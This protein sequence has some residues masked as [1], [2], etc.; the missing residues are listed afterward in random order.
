MLSLHNLFLHNLSLGLG[1]NDSNYSLITYGFFFFFFFRH[2]LLKLQSFYWVSIL[3]LLTCNYFRLL[4]F[5]MFIVNTCIQHESRFENKL[6]GV[7][8]NP[9]ISCN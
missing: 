8:C 1:F 3:F 4:L 7:F 9:L 5:E 6:C 2:I